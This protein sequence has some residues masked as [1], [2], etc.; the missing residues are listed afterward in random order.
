MLG[1]HAYPLSESHTNALTYRQAQTARCAGRMKPINQQMGLSV[2]VFQSLDWLGGGDHNTFG[3]VLVVFAALS[4][5][6]QNA[7]QRHRK[8]CHAKLNSSTIEPGA[9]DP[10]GLGAPLIR[11]AISRYASDMRARMGS[12]LRLYRP[13]YPDS[14]VIVSR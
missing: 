8:F 12:T 1:S 13:K 14:I 9:P 3:N 2:F 6:S 7:I 4:Q 10:L 5:V 11:K